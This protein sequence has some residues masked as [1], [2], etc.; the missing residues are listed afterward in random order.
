[1]HHPYLPVIYKIKMY[2][3]SNIIFKKNKKLHTY[4]CM[5]TGIDRGLRKGKLVIKVN[6]VVSFI[7]VL[8]MQA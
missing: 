4:V 2:C 1:M 7:N 6:C 8:R 5:Y 3:A